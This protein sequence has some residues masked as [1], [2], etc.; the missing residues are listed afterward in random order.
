MR[1]RRT[2]TTSEHVTFACVLFALIFLAVP[3][4][5]FVFV[6]GAKLV[7]MYLDFVFSHVL[8]LPWLLR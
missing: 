1:E 3:L 7:A 6:W 5:I 4:G 8:P 2:Y